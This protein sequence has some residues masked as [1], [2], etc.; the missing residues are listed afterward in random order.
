MSLLKPDHIYSYSQLTSFDECPYGYYLQ[1]IE[2]L[3]QQ[4][5]AFAEQGTLIHDLID[6]WAK[7]LIPA[8]DLPKEYKRR[9]PEEVVTQFPRLL[10]ARGYTEKSYDAGLR[11]FENFDQFEDLDII[12]TECKFKTDLA[13]RPFIGIIDM[14]ARNK[15]TGEFIVLD[16]KSKSL[17]SFTKDEDN[18]Y[19][20]QLLYSKFVY[21]KYNQWPD[22]MMFNLFKEDGLRMS[23]PFDR[24]AYDKAVVW[25]A[26]IMDQIEKFE[27]LDWL[28][29]KEE[30][31]FFCQNL[32]NMRSHCSNGQSKPY[33]RK[34]KQ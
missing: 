25:A 22:I 13:G 28:E 31:D 3:Q 32:C 23:R 33:K 18:M 1:R 8:E 17:N 5:N 26:G 12:D 9:Y 4:S 16:H 10:A 6:Q 15:D 27:M 7:G 29:K 14:V 30:S 11:Y 21:E 34:T 20:Q 24:F 19:R 2:G